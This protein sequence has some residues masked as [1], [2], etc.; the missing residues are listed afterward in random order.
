M[1]GHAPNPQFI[2]PLAYPAHPAYEYNIARALIQMPPLLPPA[3]PAPG[4]VPGIMAAGMAAIASRFAGD[5]L[6]AAA[7]FIG[8]L[9]AHGIN[10]WAAP[11][12]G[13]GFLT[14]TLFSGGL[15]AA[16]RPGPPTIFDH[17]HLVAP[18]GNPQVL[19][20]P[21]TWNAHFAGVVAADGADVITLVN[22][23]RNTE[24]A[25]AGTDTRYYF[26]MYSTAPPAPAG[27]GSWHHAWT[28]TLEDREDP[29]VTSARSAASLRRRPL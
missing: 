27:A 12:I 23:A 6:A 29:G 2:A 11:N 4:A 13:Q 16:V 24:D 15:A 21:R 26:Q 19:D 18:G 25:L 1:I 3:L 9:Q 28:S 10:Q 14:A 7:P 17:Y 20:Q 5:A 8:L 22:Y